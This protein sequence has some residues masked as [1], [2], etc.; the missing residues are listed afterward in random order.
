MNTPNNFEKHFKKPDVSI[1]QHTKRRI[2]TLGRSLRP[3]HAVYLDMCF[4]IALRDAVRTGSENAAL[5]LFYLLR[6]KTRAGAIFCPIS[7]N[8]FVEL[9][10]QSDSISRD[11]TG[12]LIDELSLGVTLISE[13]MRVASEVTHFFV[14]C[15]GEAEL[16]PLEELVWCKLSY[17]LGIIHPTQT[18]FDQ[19]TELAIQKAF[20]DHM[21]TIPLTRLVELVGD[22]E[23]PGRDLSKLASNLNTAIAAHA[24]ELRSFRQAYRTEV[25]GAVDMGGGFAADTIP[26]IAATRG[27]TLPEPTCEERK[28]AEKDCKNLMAAALEQGKAQDQLRTMHIL[29]SLHASLRWN[30]GQ[31]FVSNGIFDFHHATAALAYCDAFFTEGPLCA[32]IKQKHLQ[33]DKQF[34]CHVTADIE[35]AITW[36]EN[37]S[38]RVE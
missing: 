37:A 15:S 10:K 7:E 8:T 22:A 31:K 9:M 6:E 26:E 18:V 19:A 25:R 14:K 32:M 16:L 2:R 3:R 33:L 12:K 28:L 20:F 38:Q 11:A 13:D 21:W 30:K 5:R 4:W 1:D 29:A 36:I 34:G 23:I 17:V 35:D 24:Y 27:I